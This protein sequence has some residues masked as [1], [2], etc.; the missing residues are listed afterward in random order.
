MK[1]TLRLLLLAFLESQNSDKMPTPGDIA[2]GRNLSTNPLIEAKKLK[3]K[4]KKNSDPLN[5]RRNLHH[6]YH[7][8]HYHQH[9]HHHYHYHYHYHYHCDHYYHYYYDRQQQGPSNAPTNQLI[10]SNVFSCFVTGV[11]VVALIR[12]ISGTYEYNT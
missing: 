3:K 7:H 10:L 6:H 2:T 12:F 4:K 5:F 1:R 8:H 9:Q 11:F